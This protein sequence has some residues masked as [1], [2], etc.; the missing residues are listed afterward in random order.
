MN[1]KERLEAA[2]RGEKADR[3]AWAPEINDLV[4]KNVI[5][6]VEK[7]TL[8][9]LS[10]VAPDKL[11]PLQYAKSNQIVGG[12]A[13]LRVTPYKTVYEGVEF[14]KRDEG[15]EIVEWV[16]TPKGRSTARVRKEPESATD[17]RY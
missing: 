14:G 17:F 2:L 9:P 8:K 15:A 1:S 16:E 13:F 4:T 7:G 5:E 11:N 6:R 10:G 12:D 3:V